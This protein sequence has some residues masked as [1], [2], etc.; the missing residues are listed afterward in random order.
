MYLAPVGQVYRRA[1][2]E[3]HYKVDISKPNF[4]STIVDIRLI[5]IYKVV[6]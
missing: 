5:G 3:R 4:F 1:G 6:S 2:L